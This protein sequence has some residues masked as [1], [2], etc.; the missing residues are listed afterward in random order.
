MY[1]PEFPVDTPLVVRTRPG[2][3]ISQTRAEKKNYGKIK[4]VIVVGKIT[5]RL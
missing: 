3:R 1:W 4:S 2:A 5:G